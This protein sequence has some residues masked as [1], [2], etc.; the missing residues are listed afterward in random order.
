[1]RNLL[2]CALCVAFFA[3]LLAGC[4]SRTEDPDK[5]EREAFEKRKMP[6]RPPK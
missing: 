2:C 5:V 1:M 4:T 6:V 3:A